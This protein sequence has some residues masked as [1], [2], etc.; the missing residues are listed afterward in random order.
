MRSASRAFFTS[1]QELALM[2]LSDAKKAVPET[3]IREE[4]KS[5]DGARRRQKELLIEMQIRYQARLPDSPKIVITGTRED[6]VEFA[7]LI[8]LAD[9]KLIAVKPM[10]TSSPAPHDHFLQYIVI[11]SAP[12]APVRIS[13]CN[14]NQL[15][16]EGEK[17]KLAILAAH[18]RLFGDEAH[19]THREQIAYLPHHFYLDS[20]T[21]AVE[22]EFSRDSLIL[23]DKWAPILKLQPETGKGYQIGSV[24]LKNGKQ[25][26]GVIIIGTRIASVQDERKI[27]FT[28]AEIDK[29]LIDHGK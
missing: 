14:K 13:F 21:L 7:A 2:Y 15:L 12:G 8:E 1:A 27:P 19:Q 17:S 29:I 22:L 18:V 26:K 5:H 6:F 23:S 3:Q 9:E 16:I 11:R 25:F 4:E 20:D 28:E 10:P 24:H